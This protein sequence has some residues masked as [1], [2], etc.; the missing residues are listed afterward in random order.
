LNL[1]KQTGAGKARKDSYS[2][3]VLGNWA[4]NVFYD[5]MSDDVADIQ[6]TFTPMFIS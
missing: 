5:M 4:M 6:T 1:R 2:A 3:L